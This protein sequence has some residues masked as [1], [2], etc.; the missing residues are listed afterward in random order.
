MLG[1]GLLG[2]AFAAEGLYQIT[3]GWTPVIGY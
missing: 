2:A 1:I 3:V